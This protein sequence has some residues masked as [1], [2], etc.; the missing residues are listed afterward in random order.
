MSRFTTAVR[1]SIGAKLVM[2]LTGLLLLGFTIAHMVG[3]LQV[4]AGPEKLNAYAHTLQSLGPILWAMRLGLLAV[5]VLHVWTAFVLWSE[6]KAARPVPYA[7]VAPSA[8]TYASRTMIWTGFIVLA[9][10]VYHLLHFTWGVVQGDIY[11]GTRAGP[12]GHPDVYAM[13]I[14]GF[15]SAPVALAYVVAQILLGLHIS[16]GASSMFQTFGCTSPRIE[17]VKKAAGPLL[18]TL[19]VLGNCAIP[20]AILLGLVGKGVS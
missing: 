11:A 7:V 8:S 15:R 5:F 10:V 6:N 17:P 19:I 3:N 18:A 20:L 14:R 4:F 16:H 2:A 12:D 1:S 9:F 13:V